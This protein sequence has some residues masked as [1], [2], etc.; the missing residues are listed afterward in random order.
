MRSDSTCWT[1]LGKCSDRTLPLHAPLRC[2]EHKMLRAGDE[3]ELFGG[4]SL[5]R[6]G[7]HLSGSAML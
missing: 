4:A 5:L 3:K 2:N 7:G 1:L 6:L